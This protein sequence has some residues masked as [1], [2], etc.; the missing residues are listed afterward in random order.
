MF[1]R[2]RGWPSRASALLVFRDNTRPHIQ[3]IMKYENLPSSPPRLL[4]VVAYPTPLLD[5]PWSNAH[6]NLVFPKSHV[7]AQ[8]FQPTIPPPH[9]QERADIIHHYSHPLLRFLLAVATAVS[10]LVAVFMRGTY[11]FYTFLR[12]CRNASTLAAWFLTLLPV[13]S[14]PKDLCSLRYGAQLSMCLPVQRLQV[15]DVYEVTAVYPRAVKYFAKYEDLYWVADEFA[16]LGDT[17]GKLRSRAIQ[18]AMRDFDML[19]DA[20]DRLMTVSDVFVEVFSHPQGP[21]IS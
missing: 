6:Q 12:M 8:A 3:T 9:H 18:S 2:V 21:P 11:A 1:Y 16:A 14:S 20:Q 10:V 19:A 13:L 5:N 7:K 17:A 4:D 15:H